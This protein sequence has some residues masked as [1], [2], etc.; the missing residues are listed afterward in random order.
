MAEC[1]LIRSDELENELCVQGEF[2]SEAKMKDVW[3]WAPTLGKTLQTVHAVGKITALG[4]KGSHKR[5]QESR[6]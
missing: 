1:N 5:S 6:S 3:G 4:A 2:A